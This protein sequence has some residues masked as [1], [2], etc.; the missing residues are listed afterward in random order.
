MVRGPSVD[1]EEPGKLLVGHHV[2]QPAIHV[3]DGVRPQVHRDRHQIADHAGH[4]V[5]AE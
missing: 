3:L 2:D 4:L 5:E 1:A